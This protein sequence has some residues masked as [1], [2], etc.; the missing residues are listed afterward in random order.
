MNMNN[1]L[2]K[3]KLDRLH[4]IILYF[5]KWSGIMFAGYVFE[6]LK[7]VFIISFFRFILLLL[8]KLTHYVK[9]HLYDFSAIKKIKFL[10]PFIH[11]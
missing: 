7:K 8:W 9:K 5:S 2:L 10:N 1:A 6:Y 4:N 11:N 3:I